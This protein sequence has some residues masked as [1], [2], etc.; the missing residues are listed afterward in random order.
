MRS[1]LPRIEFIGGPARLYELLESDQVE[2]S[3]VHFHGEQ[4]A[5]ITY[6][7][8]KKFVEVNNTTNITVAA[9]TTIWA[10]LKHYKIIEKLGERVL[11]F[12]TDSC[13]LLEQ[14][15]DWSPPLGSYL[16][17]LTNEIAPKDGN[18][19]SG[20]PKNYAYLMDNV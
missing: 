6:N 9:F 2:M 12:D 5:E 13:V 16:G 7:F 18:F 15:E 11:Y 17:D 10:H 19:V 3:D 8:N 4:F 14:D 1:N 20:G